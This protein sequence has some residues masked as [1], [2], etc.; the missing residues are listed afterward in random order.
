MDITL[1]N[2]LGGPPLDADGFNHLPMIVNQFSANQIAPSSEVGLHAQLV[3]YDMSKSDGMNVGFNLIQSVPPGG[4]AKYT[5][6]AGKV[7]ITPGTPGNR[8]ATPIEYGAINLMASDPI[9]GSS[10]GLIGALIIEPEGATWADGSSTGS[11]K[12]KVTSADGEPGTD[13]LLTRAA[14]DIN[15]ANGNFLFRDFVVIHQDDVNMQF[16]NDVT[17]PDVL[18]PGD[19]TFAAGDPVPTV[20][21]EEEPEDSGMKGINYRTEPIW[22]RLN[23][24]PTT[25]N[26]RTV[27][28]T[29]AFSSTLGEPVTPIFTAGTNEAIRF[30]VLKPGGHNRNNVF[31]LHGHVWARHPYGPGSETI[32]PFNDNTF[33]H[34]EQMGHGPSNHINVVPLNTSRP[35][36]D[37]L[38]RDMVPTHV[39]NGE[40]GILRVVEE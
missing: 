30:R 4:I 22:L 18:V 27:D 38:Y 32:D 19:N 16:A 8:T 14:I 6:Y 31:T 17:F 25:V 9:E 10:K 12:T 23:V 28:Y 11:G 34:G 7:D 24:G 26:T 20:A 2:Q 1:T 3:E 29:D 39:N 33:W 15:D 35:E 40:W 36:G 13:G 21:A 37:Y 5:W